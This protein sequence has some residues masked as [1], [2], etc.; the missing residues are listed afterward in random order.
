M[1]RYPASSGSDK[2]YFNFTASMTHRYNHQYGGIKRG[3]R[4]L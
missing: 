2:A 4:R 3:G 1:S